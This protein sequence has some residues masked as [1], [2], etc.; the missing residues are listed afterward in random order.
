MVIYF[1][2]PSI[3]LVFKLLTQHL[4]PVQLLKYVMTLKKNK[5]QKNISWTKK[6]RHTCGARA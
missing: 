2:L 3:T 1:N 4:N 5:K 6:T